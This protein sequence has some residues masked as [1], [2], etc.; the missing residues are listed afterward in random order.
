MAFEVVERPNGGDD[1]DDAELMAVVNS[2][3]N[4]K[5]VKVD[6]R[7]RNFVNWQSNLR[8]KLRKRGLKLRARRDKAAKVV[9]AWAEPLEDVDIE[10]RIEQAQP[11][12]A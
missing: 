1:V 6:V 2:A 7:D 12:D 9:V 3:E 5:A 4:G 8:N 10:E 11:V